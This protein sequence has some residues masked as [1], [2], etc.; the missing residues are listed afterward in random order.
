MVLLLR[1]LASGTVE[2]SEETPSS[3]RE[4][5]EGEWGKCLQ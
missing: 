1:F 5:E 2:T 3:L 4:L